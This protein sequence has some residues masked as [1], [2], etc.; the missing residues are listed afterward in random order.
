M[1][2]LKMLLNGHPD[3]RVHQVVQENKFT[4]KDNLVTL[5]PL[6]GLSERH[7]KSSFDGA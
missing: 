2:I 1:D 4:R 6:R 5:S 3:F 7:G